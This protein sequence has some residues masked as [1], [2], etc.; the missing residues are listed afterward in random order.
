MASLNK[1]HII[2]HLG[3][4][5]ELTYSKS[6]MAFAKFSIATSE[7]KK[8]DAGEWEEKTDWHNITL[9]GKTAEA[10]GQYLAKGKQVYIEGRIS[11]NSWEKDG[12]KQYFTN[13]LGS[14]MVMLGSKGDS[15]PA[16]QQPPNTGFK[17]SP[18]QNAR[19]QQAPPFDPSDDS[20]ELPF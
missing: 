9:F 2:G 14:R 13:I 7:R 18:Q 4:D 17:G 1:V 20:S 3:K 11:Y 6:G 5:P 12:V 16:Q 10:A 8:N 19:P 15:Q